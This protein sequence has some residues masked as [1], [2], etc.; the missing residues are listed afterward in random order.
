[1]RALECIAADGVS[2]CIDL[3]RLLDRFGKQ[4]RY[5]YHHRDLVN[6]LSYWKTA[7]AASGMCIAST[8]SDDRK[9]HAAS[10]S[11]NDKDNDLLEE[12]KR[13]L[14]EFSTDSLEKIQKRMPDEYKDIPKQVNDFLESGKGGQISW[15]FAMG[16][17]SGFALKKVSKVGAIA[18]GTLFV[19]MQCAS[20]S[21]YI[22]VNYQ[23]LERDVMDFLDINKVCVCV[24]A[25]LLR[26]LFLC[27]MRCAN[28]K[29]T[30]RW[31]CL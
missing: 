21:G 18:L 2:V 15:G 22:D 8:L 20:Y 12:V 5:D 28:P 6:P 9:A 7:L 10:S 24:C 3:T 17:C 19:V 1:M 31:D 29:W 16:V 14:H 25:F 30:M 13:K 26:S 23:K 4:H 11:G 27:S